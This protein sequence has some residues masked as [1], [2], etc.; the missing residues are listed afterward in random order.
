[1]DELYDKINEATQAAF[2]AIHDGRCSKQDKEYFTEIYGLLDE[3]RHK[4]GQA[5]HQLEYEKT[6][7]E[8]WKSKYLE[9]TG[10]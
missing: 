3:A 6:R 2:F 10:E 4:V 1:M 7:A 8:V 9:E 5:L